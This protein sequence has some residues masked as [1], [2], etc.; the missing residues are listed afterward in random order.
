MSCG[1][2]NW[3][4]LVCC[5]KWRCISSGCSCVAFTSHFSLQMAVMP[6]KRCLMCCLLPCSSF[7]WGISSSISAVS[8]GKAQQKNRISACNLIWEWLQPQTCKSRSCSVCLPSRGSDRALCDTC[9]CQE[10][11]QGWCNAHS[12]HTVLAGRKAGA[13]WRHVGEVHAKELSSWKRKE[14]AR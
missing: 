6:S 9:W 11:V 13:F 3:K 12:T 2:P 5:G 1:R 8:T 7:I 4:E 10:G 14:L